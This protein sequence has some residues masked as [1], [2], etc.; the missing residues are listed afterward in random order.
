MP[1][2]NKMSFTINHPE[3]MFMHS[4]VIKMNLATRSTKNW[5]FENFQRSPCLANFLFLALNLVSIVLFYF[6]L[7]SSLSKYLKSFCDL[8]S[9]SILNL[10]TNLNFLLLII[11][12][13][14]KTGMIFILSLVLLVIFVIVIRLANLGDR[15]K[16]GFK[17]T[18]IK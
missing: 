16:S 7:I 10:S 2:N 13:L 12:L 1:L 11:F 6:Y 15:W 4:M 8:A 9:K 5:R 14:Q 17:S 3:N 18:I